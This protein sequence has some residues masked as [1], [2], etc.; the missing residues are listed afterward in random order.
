MTRPALRL[1]PGAA[2][3]VLAAVVSPAAIA[4]TQAGQSAT[5][6]ARVGR[7][8]FVDGR[9]VATAVVKVTGNTTHETTIGPIT[10]APAKRRIAIQAF[11][12]SDDGHWVAWLETITKRDGSSTAARPTLVV[13]TFAP[14]Q[15]YEVK[16][17]ALPLGFASDKLVV[18]NHGHASYVDLKTSATFHKIPGTVFPQA[19]YP[20][21]VVNLKALTSPPG[22]KNTE[23]LRLTAFDGSAQI[24]HN[25]VL[26]PSNAHLPERSFVSPDGKVL[27]VER[28][29]HTDFGGIGSTSIIDEFSLHGPRDRRTIGHYGSA[30]KQWRVGAMSFAWKNNEPW[31]VW[32]RA[33]RTGAASVL[34]VYQHDRWKRIIKHGIAVL[35]ARNGFVIAQAGKYV[36][37]R[38]GLGFVRK[39]TGD[40]MLL[41]DHVVKVMGIQG[42]AFAWVD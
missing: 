6:S 26:K 8:A 25:Y 42:S 19:A 31:V 10:H 13:R 2:V 17:T 32:E 37:N 23:Q 21:G 33:T 40:A 3:V 12:G 7:V 30:K 22:P 28:G 29:D 34:A 15:V 11:V 9:H 39:P 41:H 35:G 24:V 27:A 18:Y 5:A 1:L 14:D 36:F 38:D 4:T 20:G 16:T